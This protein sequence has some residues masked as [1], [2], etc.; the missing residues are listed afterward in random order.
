MG[1]II[2]QMTAINDLHNDQPKWFAVYTKYKCEK[3]VAANL[4]RKDI[5]VYLPLLEK[6]KIYASKTKKYKVPLISCFVFVRIT[7]KDYIKV[8]E[9]EYVLNFLRQRKDLISIPENEINIL[10]RLLGEYEATVHEEKMN[11]TLGQKMEV[12]AGQLTGLKGI[13]VQEANNSHF[14]V[15]LENIGVKLRM[16]FNSNHLMPII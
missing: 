7:K 3:Y 2:E 10:K 9:T 13:L 5:K 15:E 16:Q 12:I 11:W 4:E 6:V 1:G 8:I 14:I